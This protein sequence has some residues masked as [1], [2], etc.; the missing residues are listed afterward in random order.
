MKFF[1]AMAILGLGGVALF[2]LYSLAIRNFHISD[3]ES[4][5]Q[6]LLD[7]VYQNE[8]AFYGEHGF[9]SSESG[10]FEEVDVKRTAI[11]GFFPDC[12][13]GSSAVFAFLGL[14]NPSFEAHAKQI[15]E[16]EFIKGECRNTDTQFTAFAA[17]NLDEDDDFEL[18]SIDENNQTKVIL[19]D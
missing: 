12:K 2:A 1:K 8:K 3:E 6:V 17:Q 18:W 14:R 4:D 5:L 10:L 15:I 11:V 9:Y 16:Q 19:T 7:S 13:T